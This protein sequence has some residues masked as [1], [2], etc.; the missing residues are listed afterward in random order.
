[1]GTSDMKPLAEENKN[2]RKKDMHTNLNRSS[3]GQELSQRDFPSHPVSSILRLDKETSRT[4][5]RTT[6]ATQEFSA[7]DIEICL[8]RYPVESVTKFELKQNET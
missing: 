5:A 2:E 8:D 7:G 1:M 3:Q 4:L 6:T